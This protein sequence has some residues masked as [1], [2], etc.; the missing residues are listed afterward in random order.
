MGL[1]ELKEQIEQLSPTELQELRQYIDML[2]SNEVVLDP[3]PDQVWQ[4]VDRRENS[5]HNGE[6]QV[7]EALELVMELHKSIS[8]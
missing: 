3:L 2:Q 7:T 8:S 4:A 1:Q 5:Y 6:L